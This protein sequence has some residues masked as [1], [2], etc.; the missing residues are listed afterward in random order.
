MERSG[1]VDDSASTHALLRTLPI[2][3][4]ELGGGF[5]A[6]RQRI[7]RERSIPHGY[8]M[9]VAAGNLDNLRNATTG[10]GAFRGPV[11]VDSD[12]YKWLEAAAWELGRAPDPALRRRVDEAIGIVGAAQ[13][14]DGYINSYWQVVHPN[15]RWTDLPHGHELYCIGH[16]IQAAVAMCRATG[17]D[18]LLRIAESAVRCVHATF[19]VGRRLGVPGHPEIE[20][21]LVEIYRHTGDQTALDLARFFLDHRGHGLLRDARFYDPGY[22]QDRV[23]IREST[24]IE[25]HAVRAV[26]LLSGIVDAYLETGEGALLATAQSQS[27]DM[28]RHKQYITGAIGSRHFTE[29]FGD[30]YELPA[31]AAY[32]ET[33]AA[34]GNVFWNWRM[35]LATGDAAY[36][37]QI[38][39]TLF[40]AVMS[41]VGMDGTTFFYENPLASTGV[42]RREPWYT[43]ACCPPNIM[44]LLASLQHYIAT[45]D[46]RGIQLH[47]FASGVLTHGDVVLDV[48]TE[49]PWDGTVTVEIRA[50]P[51]SEWKLALR[52]PRWCREPALALN[53]RAAPHDVRSGYAVLGRRWSRGDVVALN[54]PMSARLM[55]SHPSIESARAS[56]AITRGPLVYCVE[57]CDQPREVTAMTTISIDPRVALQT[58]A[59]SELPGGAIAVTGSGFSRQGRVWDGLYRPLEEALDVETRRPFALTAVPYFLWANRDPGPMAV[60]IPTEGP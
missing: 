25:G 53:G 38:E 49:Y 60:W 11:F 20:S 2:D 57:M 9:L 52:L 44:R 10:G 51:E 35:L 4:F 54:L 31:A 26:Y 32:A 8:E 22:Y 56:V 29:S 55:A 45:A 16:L 46:A 34:I 3:A 19:G 42:Q 27:K 39:W 37:D 18:R 50:S 5:W 41:G 36:A 13:A 21:A 14:D 23:P 48:S 58:I 40:N 28:V 12:V 33:C 1:P 59:R 17:D 15:A 30:P 47:Q 6:D 43:C 24:T 7:N